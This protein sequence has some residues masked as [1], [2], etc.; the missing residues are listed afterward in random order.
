GS[1]RRVDHFPSSVAHL[2]DERDGARESRNVDA[3]RC[4][5][6]LRRPRPCTRLRMVCGRRARRHYPR[7]APA[8][9]CPAGGTRMTNIF[10]LP[11]PDEPGRSW[12]RAERERLE[13]AAAEILAALGLD[14]DTPGTRETP[15]RFLQALYDA[16]AGYD[17]DPKLRTLFPS[18]RPDDIEG[19][20]A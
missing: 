17:G 11:H 3:A 1:S 8:A 15:Q 14:L 13:Q 10:E 5:R 12:T 9:Q 6:T 7:S 19:A 4:V 18:E 16:T 20:H 2:A